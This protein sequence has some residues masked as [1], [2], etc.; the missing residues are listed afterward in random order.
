ML[1]DRRIPPVRS[2]RPTSVPSAVG[3]MDWE[4]AVG[5]MD[6]ESADFGPIEPG[7]WED[8]G[9][10][11]VHQL[12]IIGASAGCLPVW[13]SGQLTQQITKGKFARC[14]WSDAGRME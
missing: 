8:P 1:V 13:E 5:S 9:R 2:L 11:P 3:S 4:S 12:P 10:V 14:I 6:W 7:N